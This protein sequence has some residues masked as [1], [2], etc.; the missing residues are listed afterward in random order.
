MI[1]FT[2]RTNDLGITHSDQELYL[3]ARDSRGIPTQGERNLNLEPCT[4]YLALMV[5]M[6]KGY[7]LLP[8]GA[9]RT[10]PRP[11]GTMHLT[12]SGFVGTDGEVWGSDLV[13]IVP[14]VPATPVEIKV[15]V[16]G[17]EKMINYADAQK[18]G[19]V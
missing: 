6:P 15:I 1:A 4:E 18:L 2:M 8:A 12:P 16:A 19:L 10:L 17:K 14:D 3:A 13:Y 9:A 5:P 7:E 11:E